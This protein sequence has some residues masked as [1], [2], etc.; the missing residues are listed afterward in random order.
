MIE[1]TFGDD[2]LHGLQNRGTK[3]PHLARDDDSLRSKQ[4]HQI[5]N[6]ISDEL[7]L[8]FQD[9]QYPGIPLGDQSLKLRKRQLATSLSGRIFKNATQ[10]RIQ[11]DA[12]TVSAVTPLPMTAIDRRVA[13]F[14][15]DSEIARIQTPPH[16]DTG[17]DTI[18]EVHKDEIRSVPTLT[19]KLLRHG[20]RICVIDDER[21]KTEASCRCCRA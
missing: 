16:D 15:R 5:D 20:F 4:V 13:D 17:T 18:A 19:K 10:T 12:P 8:L 2:A 11:L 7:T 9:P 21:R 3:S 14:A 1:A 6:G